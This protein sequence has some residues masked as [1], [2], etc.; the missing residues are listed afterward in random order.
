MSDHYM[1]D[2]ED[3]ALDLFM[4]EQLIIEK[5]QFKD[6][7]PFHEDPSPEPEE[8]KFPDGKFIEYF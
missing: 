1:S 7:V 4:K 6:Q 2:R 5:T 8:M 3:E